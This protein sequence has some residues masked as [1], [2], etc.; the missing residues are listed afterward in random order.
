[1]MNKDSKKKEK[2]KKKINA[3]KNGDL[4][5]VETRIKLLV[6]TYLFIIYKQICFNM[7]FIQRM[8]FFFYFFIDKCISKDK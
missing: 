6:E 2:G 3:V 8:Y 7:Y 5:L 1:M 4:K